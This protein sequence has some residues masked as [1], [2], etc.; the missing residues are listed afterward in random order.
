[1]L[2]N[3]ASNNPACRF[4]LLVGGD[5]WIT[6]GIAIERDL[7]ALITSLSEWENEDETTLHTVG[8]RGNP[9]ETRIASSGDWGTALVGPEFSHGAGRLGGHFMKATKKAHPFLRSV[10]GQLTGTWQGMVD[11][12]T[13]V[14]A[15]ALE[16]NDGQQY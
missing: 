11:L 12:A 15:G 4:D 9:T 2:H 13:G 3:Y 10:A 6:R 5:I 16:Q 7:K 1:L 14:S 8:E